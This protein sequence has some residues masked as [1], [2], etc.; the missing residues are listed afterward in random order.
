MSSKL[1]GYA[2][3]LLRINLTDGSV[4]VEPPSREVIRGFI[5]GST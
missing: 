1:Y 3:K 4:K 2:G 5:G